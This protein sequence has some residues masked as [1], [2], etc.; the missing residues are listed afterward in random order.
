MEAGFQAA[1]SVTAL[2]LVFVAGRNAAFFAGEAG[3]IGQQVSGTDANASG[4]RGESGGANGVT[5]AGKMGDELAMVNAGQTQ[6]L[7]ACWGAAKLAGSGA[8]SGEDLLAGKH[9]EVY[10]RIKDESNGAFQDIACSSRIGWVKLA[11]LCD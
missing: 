3:P 2:A 9:R 11:S 7:G 10:P 8:K 1:K 5:I 6:E 4:I